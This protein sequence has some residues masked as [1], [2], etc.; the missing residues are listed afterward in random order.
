MKSALVLV[1]LSVFGFIVA[2]YNN[3]HDT[4]M[5]KP[6]IIVE[7]QKEMKAVKAAWNNMFD[8]YRK[9]NCNIDKDY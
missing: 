6:E 4:W 3:C 9:V 5:N 7:I 8:N 2:D 1:L